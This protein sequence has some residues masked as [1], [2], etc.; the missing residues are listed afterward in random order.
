MSRLR[1]RLHARFSDTSSPG[2]IRR[3][4]GINNVGFLANNINAIGDYPTAGIWS[5][6]GVGA[7]DQPLANATGFWRD[8]NGCLVCDPLLVGLD[9]NFGEFY[10]NIPTNYPAPV[11]ASRILRSEV[12]IEYTLMGG[13]AAVI[14]GFNITAYSPILGYAGAFVASWTIQE[15]AGPLTTLTEGTAGLGVVAGAFADEPELCSNKIKISSQRVNAG[16]KNFVVNFWQRGTN[17]MQTVTQNWAAAGVGDLP[18]MWIINVTQANGSKMLIKR[19][20][21]SDDAIA[22]G[23]MPV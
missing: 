1:Q 6:D 23:N 16:S 12:L 18:I 5:F 4:D 22:Y 7:I 17:T 3:R 9:C 2:N 13:I 11:L 14:T 20:E 19:L 8:D 10:D 21:M 15:V